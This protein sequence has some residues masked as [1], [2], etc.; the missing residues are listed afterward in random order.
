MRYFVKTD[1]EVYFLHWVN[2]VHS[3]LFYKMQNARQV[4]CEFISLWFNND[5]WKIVGKHILRVNA[6]GSSLHIFYIF[7]PNKIDGC[8]VVKSLVS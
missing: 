1:N 7:K 6:A 8:I 2:L 3:A 4:C 5:A